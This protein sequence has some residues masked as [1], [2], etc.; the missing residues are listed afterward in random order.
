MDHDGVT[1]RRAVRLTGIAVLIAVSAL[2]CA[3]A[4]GPTHVNLSEVLALNHQSLDYQK[5]VDYRLPRALAAAIT[6]A[7]LALGGVT[8]QVLV[9]N[10]LASPFVLGVSSGGSLGAALALSLGATFVGPWAFLGCLG[11]VVIVFL[12]GRRHGKLSSTSLL[13]AGVITNATLSAVIT[14][15]NLVAAPSDRDRILRWLV[16]GLP[17]SLDSS[18]L[19]LSAASVLVFL[20]HLLLR[21]REL[22][23]MAVS[24]EM[25][26]RGCIS[27]N[28]LRIEFFVT[29]SALTAAAVTLAGPI[30]FVGLVVPH[31][32]RLAIGPDH[33]LTVPVAAF[34]GAAFVML[35]DMAAQSL[36]REPLPAGVLTAAIGGPLFLIMLRNLDRERAGLDG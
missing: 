5:V 35:A 4:V 27:V 1:L 10:P 7:A 20:T 28:R 16:G 12:A 8:F 26:A 31:L 3:L 18:S 25:A 32:T 33:R 17:E 36:W 23:L 24:D 6:G 19:L 13:L 14:F 22:N 2:V 21:S 15:I 11:A 9:R 29:G 34:G 30:P